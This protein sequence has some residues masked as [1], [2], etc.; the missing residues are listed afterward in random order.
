MSGSMFLL[1]GYFYCGR[2][3]WRRLTYSELPPFLAP[4]S[5]LACPAGL[6]PVPACS[7]WR[8]GSEPLRRQPDRAAREQK[9]FAPGNL[10]DG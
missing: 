7:R 5:A 1:G 2:V 3:N 9:P 4:S 10:F 8:G 6:R